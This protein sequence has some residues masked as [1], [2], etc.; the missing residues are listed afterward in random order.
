MIVQFIISPG[1]AV[2]RPRFLTEESADNNENCCNGT[3]SLLLGSWIS[4]A[5]ME[6]GCRGL[7]GVWHLHE[8]VEDITF[9]APCMYLERT[10]T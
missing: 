8:V 4:A 9:D 2:G 7:D 10:M 3:C 5:V 6:F 1:K